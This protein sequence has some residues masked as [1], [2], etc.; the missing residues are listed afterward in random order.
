MDIMLRISSF[1]LNCV[2]AQL[3]FLEKKTKKFINLSLVKRLGPLGIVHP[4]YK[5]FAPLLV[6]RARLDAAV[7]FTRWTADGDAD[8]IV[9]FCL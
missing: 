5:A 4:R 6:S 8:Y 7:A 2:F 9:R 1:P 3:L